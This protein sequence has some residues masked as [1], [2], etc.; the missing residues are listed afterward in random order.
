MID[1]STRF[2][3]FILSGVVLNILY[4]LVRTFLPEMKKKKQKIYGIIAL[5]IATCFGIL[6]LLM[7]K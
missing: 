4:I 7:R 1:K 5:I 2:F 6:T 3:L